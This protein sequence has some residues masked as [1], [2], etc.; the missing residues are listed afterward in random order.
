M[1]KRSSD[2][3]SG[4]GSGKEVALRNNVQF[5]KFSDFVDEFED[6]IQLLYLNVVKKASKFMLVREQPLSLQLFAECLFDAFHSQFAIVAD[7]DSVSG[8][9]SEE[10]E[11]EETETET[12]E[13]AFDSGV[14]ES[15][16]PSQLTSESVD[17]DE[18]GEVDED[19]AELESEEDEGSGLSVEEIDDSSDVVVV[20]VPQ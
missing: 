1:S 5:L 16:D 18:D 7:E 9:V 2:S 13:S 11:S 6:D 14:L 10:C 3:E 17:D 4:S 8:E 12:E 20:V 15:D 19:D